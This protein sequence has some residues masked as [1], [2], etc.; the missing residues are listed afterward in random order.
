LTFVD[1]TNGDVVAVSLTCVVACSCEA[2]R[3]VQ[4]VTNN[5]E[6]PARDAQ[7]DCH[8]LACGI[9]FRILGVLPEVR[10]GWKDDETD[11]RDV[12]L[13]IEEPLRLPM[14][15]LLNRNPDLGAILD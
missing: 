15:G 3:V 13:E 14:S 7:D 8:R 6:K 4:D 12:L 11:G 1:D 10:I 9:E 5:E 2:P